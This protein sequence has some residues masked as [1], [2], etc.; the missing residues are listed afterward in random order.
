[1]G[2]RD[3]CGVSDADESGVGG[4]ASMAVC[5]DGRLRYF[6]FGGGIQDEEERT[7]T[8]VAALQL[9]DG[10]GVQRHV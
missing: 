3:P 5:A 9:L 7:H 10:T 6:I 1:M 2:G 8:S 4:R